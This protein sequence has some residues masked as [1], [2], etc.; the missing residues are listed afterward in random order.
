MAKELICC[1]GSEVL[2]RRTHLIKQKEEILIKPLFVAIVLLRGD[3]WK[4][5]VEGFQSGLQVYS[6]VLG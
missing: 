1:G 5:R 6:A 3:F 2:E 4:S